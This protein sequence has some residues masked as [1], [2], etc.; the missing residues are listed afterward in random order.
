MSETHGIWKY[1]YYSL[2]VHSSPYHGLSL[3][4]KNIVHAIETKTEQNGTQNGGI[5]DYNICKQK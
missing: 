1:L 4:P 2:K 5:V 3:I